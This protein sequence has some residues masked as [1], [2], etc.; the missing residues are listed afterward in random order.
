MV[1]LIWVAWDIKEDSIKYVVFSIETS[2]PIPIVFNKIK[3]L[4]Q[5]FL[6]EFFLPRRA[7]LLVVSNAHAEG[8]NTQ[9]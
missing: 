7:G 6:R 5:V 3:K 2:V 8:L 1:H 9:Y 4:L